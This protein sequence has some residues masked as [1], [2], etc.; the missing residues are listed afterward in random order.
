LLGLLLGFLLLMGLLL[1]FLLGLV[2]G[3]LLGI[4]LGFRLGTLLGRGTVE[5]NLFQPKWQY[6][7]PFWSWA[8]EGYNGSTQSPS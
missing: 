5:M 4:R 1:C 7:A 2:L 8:V 3:L 6:V